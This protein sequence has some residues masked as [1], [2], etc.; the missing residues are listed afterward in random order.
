MDKALATAGSSISSISNV[1]IASNNILNSLN[2]N[3][4]NLTVTNLTVTNML[5]DLN[6]C[7]LKYLEIS[8]LLQYTISKI[9]NASLYYN[10]GVLYIVSSFNNFQGNFVFNNITSQTNYTS[11]NTS[12]FNVYNSLPVFG[13]NPASTNRI[14]RG[15]IFSYK[16]STNI[17]HNALLQFYYSNSDITGNHYFALYDQPINP[18]TGIEYTS[19]DINNIQSYLNYNCLSNL[20]LNN[21]K[22]NT[23]SSINNQNIVFNNQVIF[24]NINGGDN[25]ITINHNLGY[26]AGITFNT[27]I[28]RIYFNSLFNDTIFINNNLNVFS[29]IN[30]VNLFINNGILGVTGTSY[31]YGN[32]N[33]YG[34]LGIT[35]SFGLTGPSNF[36]GN[37]NIYGRLGVTGSLGI[38][39]PSNFYGNSNIYGDL[40][41]TGSLGITGPSNFY[42]NS[43]IYGDLGVTGSLG[44]TGPSNFYGNSNIYGDLGVTGYLGV[45]GPSNLYGN[46]NIYGNLGVTGSLGV[47]GPS[48]L[49]G[50]SNIYGNL[51]VTGSL[52]VTG[53]SIFYGNSNIYGDLGVTGSLGITGA[54]KLNGNLEVSKKIITPAYIYTVFDADDGNTIGTSIVNQYISILTLNITILKNI[55]I[56]VGVNGQIIKIVIT[57]PVS[58]ISLLQINGQSITNSNAYEYYY[59]GTSSTWIKIN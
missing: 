1:T 59:D 35:G 22:L 33:I 47:T 11:I 24:N 36:Y 53:P 54:L 15:I 18:S 42:G 51:G 6:L 49:Y 16:S 55:V 3:S 40:G 4:S 8:D 29:T 9:G 37:S 39:G 20:L 19:N 31:F 28:A 32:S 10:N 45:T 41:V 34:N 14:D 23:I 58:F 17:S 38:T 2:L 26:F 25:F 7:Y 21:I 43:N 27:S 13:T 50:N 46:S 48:N 44:I 57:N 30:S 52:G 5:T 56:G 12:L